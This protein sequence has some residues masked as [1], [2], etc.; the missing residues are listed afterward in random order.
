MPTEPEATVDSVRAIAR[1]DV[2]YTDVGRR[3]LDWR[4]LSVPLKQSTASED[5]QSMKSCQSE[6][7]W[8]TPPSNIEDERHS[9]SLS[10]SLST[11]GFY[12]TEWVVLSPG[13][14]R[15]ADFIWQLPSESFLPWIQDWEVDT[16]SPKALPTPERQLTAKDSPNVLELSAQQ[17][18]CVAFPQ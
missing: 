8:D 2:A 13:R 1:V 7:I 9:S 16:G 18:Q 4:V 5:A 14:R 6:N 11:K 3:L 10:S 12:Q 15:V 17:S